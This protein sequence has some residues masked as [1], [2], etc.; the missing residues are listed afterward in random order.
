[1]G[2]H[3]RNRLGMRLSKSFNTRISGLMALDLTISV[4]L[5]TFNGARFLRAQLR[6][7][8][9]QS[10]TPNE[11]VI[12]DDAS[13]DA[14]FEIAN[15]FARE[16]SFPVRVIRNG[17][18]LGSTK[19]FEKAI[20]LCTGDIVALSDQDD[21]W[22]REKLACIEKEFCG[23][24]AP[25]A[26]FS[27]ADLIDD[28]GNPL[29]MRLWESFSFGPREQKHFAKGEGFSILIKHPVVTGATMAFRRR[30][31][32]LILPIP[33]TYV[34][35]SW[36]SFLMAA[37]G[38]VAAL[39]E[40]LMQYRVHSRQQIGPG[41]FTLF[42]RIA[43]AQATGPE[44]YLE[45]VARFR[46]LQQRLRTCSPRFPILPRVLQEIGGKISHR[47]HRARLP[48]GKVARI[49]GVVREILNGGY[50]CY[51]EGWKSALKDIVG[52][53]QMRRDEPVRKGSLTYG[54]S[55]ERH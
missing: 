51:S 27:D 45:E 14:S 49:Q 21:A 50:W 47:E 35:D 11:V 1:M 31:S 8:A 48:V 22:Y 46:Q 17:E 54:Q 25:T 2:S 23:P 40:P 20:S 53:S 43:S 24:T 26:V 9:A 3:L 44:F 7:I 36:I 4:A 10:R 16:A 32:D 55:S 19:N 15:Q 39:S 6:S 41:L 12:S 34:H 13:T 33:P 42:E 29:P 18:T 30:F 37:C 5:C 52:F 38:P 28:S